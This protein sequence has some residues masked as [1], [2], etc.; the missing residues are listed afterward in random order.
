MNPDDVAKCSEILDRLSV[1]F[2][3]KKGD[4]VVIDNKLVMHARKNFVPPRRILAAL[5]Q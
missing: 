2:K 5:F 4:I 3:W 1:S